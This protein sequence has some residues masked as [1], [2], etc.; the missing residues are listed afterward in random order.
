MI[1]AFASKGM[2]HVIELVQ[3]HG[4]MKVIATSPCGA[5]ES[6]ADGVVQ[7]PDWTFD[8]RKT[9]KI[10]NEGGVLVCTRCS[11]VV[12]SLREPPKE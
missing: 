1:A 7:V 12:K 2:L 4:M 10:H 9:A 8:G 5:S 3:R 6:A 11:E